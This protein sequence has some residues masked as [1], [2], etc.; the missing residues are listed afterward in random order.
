MHLLL[1]FILEAGMTEEPVSA[2]TANSTSS[3]IASTL[4]IHQW[5]TMKL[6]WFRS[7]TKIDRYSNMRYDNYFFDKCINVRTVEGSG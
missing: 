6:E 3:G 7:S 4:Q 2:A 5:E 1:S